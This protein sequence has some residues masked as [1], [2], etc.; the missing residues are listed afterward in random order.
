MRN[1]DVEKHAGSAKRSVMIKASVETVWKKLSEITK[2]GWLEEQKSTKFLSQ[3]KYGVGAIRL[4]SFEDGSD[5]EEHIVE[6]SP[7]KCF[8]YI[9]IT[10]LPLLS[11]LA[12]ISM[13][14]ATSGRVK[15]T[16]QSCFVSDKKKKEFLEFSKFLSQFYL[17]SLQNLKSDIER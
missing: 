5:V 12:T 15:V 11:Y 7:K 17:K 9:A 16:W 1:F 8:S 3:K 10:G 13:K 6:W 4:I 14:K 2:L